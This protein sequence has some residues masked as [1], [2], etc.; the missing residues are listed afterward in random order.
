MLFIAAIVIVSRRKAEAVEFNDNI[1][2]TA[3]SGFSVLLSFSLCSYVVHYFL[4]YTLICM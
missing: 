4:Y 3:Y 1:I 2:I